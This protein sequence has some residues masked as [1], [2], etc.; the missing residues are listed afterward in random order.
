MHLR[1][2]F[3]EPPN[4]VRTFQCMKYLSCLGITNFDQSSATD[5]EGN[6]VK[7]VYSVCSAFSI[8]YTNTLPLG[9]A[10][11]PILPHFC[12]FLCFLWSPFLC[13]PCAAIS[14][15]YPVWGFYFTLLPVLLIQIINRDMLKMSVL[16]FSSNI[17]I[18]L[19]L[20]Q[21]VSH[22]GFLALCMLGEHSIAFCLYLQGCL[23]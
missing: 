19:S 5:F 6:R 15:T 20:V 2:S 17:L 18:R 13:T 14:S 16:K 10:T 11:N 3:W 23:I 1:L 21:R 12:S 9:T 22:M 4:S 7:V 8:E